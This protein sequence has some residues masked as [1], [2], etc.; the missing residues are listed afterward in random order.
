[1]SQGSEHTTSSEEG[2]GD[3]PLTQ[4]GGSDGA[5]SYAATVRRPQSSS[6]SVAVAPTG[7]P[8]APLV[9]PPSEH[10]RGDKSYADMLKGECSG[11]PQE[12]NMDISP[13][14]LDELIAEGGNCC[15][16]S[17]TRDPYNHLSIL[18]PKWRLKE[19]II[20]QVNV[21]YFTCLQLY[22]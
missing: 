22:D 21:L 5:T 8:R 17:N 13:L 18:K 19:Y 12:A 4:P 14:S 1:M 3:R 11:G 20:F 7:K 10:L 15:F 16:S 9:A 6:S 2:S